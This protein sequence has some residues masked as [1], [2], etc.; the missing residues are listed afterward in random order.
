[1][2]ASHVDLKPSPVRWSPG[3]VTTEQLGHLVEPS[4]LRCR[5]LLN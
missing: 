4:W 1:M 3:E 5:Q 2:T